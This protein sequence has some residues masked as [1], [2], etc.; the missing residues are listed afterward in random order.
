MWRSPSGDGSGS[1]DPEVVEL[2]LRLARDN[3][4]WGYVRIVREA[5]KGRCQGVGDIGTAHL[6]PPRTR[7]GGA[8]AR[9]ADVGG[10]PACP[11]R[12]NLGV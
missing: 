4:R 1:L 5:R 8:A 7:S 10:V 9:W 3:P 11:G 12:G 6:T 2:V